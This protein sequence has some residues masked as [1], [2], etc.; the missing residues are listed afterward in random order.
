MTEH[1]A[2]V[3]RAAIPKFSD[4]SIAFRL[5]MILLAAT[6]VFAL[7]SGARAEAAFAMA[8]AAILISAATGAQRDVAPAM[9]L[10]RRFSVAM[11]L[12]VVWMMLQIM[13]QPFSSL[14]N[15]IWSTA[16]IALNDP[17]LW[18]RISLDPGSTMRGLFHYL[19][20]LSLLTGT[21]I[22]TRDRHRAETTLL[23]LSIVTAF[24]SLELLLG[25][26]A[27]F[28]GIIPNPVEA[29]ITVAALAVL[30]GGAVIIMAIE[31]HLSRRDQD[32]SSLTP[33]L[34]RLAIGLTG[35]VLGIAAASS[36]APRNLLV[37]IA[38][39]CA[40][41]LFI[42]VVRRI[43]LRTW[44][45][46]TLFL[47]F[48]GLATILLIPHLQNS[49]S[50]GIAGFAAADGDSLSLAER[51]LSDTPWLGNGVGS[52]AFLSQVYR[53]F[54]AAPTPAPPSTAISVAVEWGFSGLVALAALALLV[55]AALFMGAVRRGR[56]SFYASAAAAGILALLCGAFCDSGLLLPATQ[57]AA[58]V[59]V[60]LGLAQSEGR[61]KGDAG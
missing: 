7:T 11:L 50:A 15:P 2:L 25:R 4:L 1:L 54:G 61:T 27:E 36:L 28:A 32:E 58:A 3:S 12:P 8:A 6:P 34:S 10:I 52:F 33:L 45:S 59:M 51:A 47:I 43:G 24:I 46:L 19:A 35:T 48:A 29:L 42:A 26:L 38:L 18:G 57:I 56:D 40:T 49:R 55:S 53:D 23:V 31:R 60:G 21:I 41:L 22:V 44:P 13:P 14:T 16:A 20:M 37:A 9:R 39:G 17:T 5:L 30:A